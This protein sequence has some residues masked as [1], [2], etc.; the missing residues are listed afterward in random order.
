M[1]MSAMGSLGEALPELEGGHHESLGEWESGIHEHHEGEAEAEQFF[2]GL[3]RLAARAVRSPTFRRLAATAARSALSGLGALV[4]GSDSEAL[5]EYEYEAA[6]LHEEELSP[7][8][9]VYSDALMEHLGSMAAETESEAEA[10]AH[11]RAMVPLA[12]RVVPRAA[13]VIRRAAPGLIRGTTSVLHTLRRS[14]TVRPLVRAIPAIVRGT[15]VSLAR[16]VA[17]GHPVTPRGAVRLLA[18]QTARVLG[19]PRL[20]VQAYRRSRWLDRRYHTLA[21]SYPGAIPS[22]R[23]YPLYYPGGPWRGSVT[24][25][26][27][28]V[29]GVPTY[30]PGIGGTAGMPVDLARAGLRPARGARWGR[31]CCGCCCGCR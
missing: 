8:R 2:G 28:G 23:R 5:H 27:A 3:A 4:S 6:A 29:G 31:C 1:A 7:I 20:G 15:A 13:P 17:A 12:A 16:Q 21:R 18:R 10:R 26:P 11:V 22:Y 14:P 19:N 24:G 25:G 30:R 9:R